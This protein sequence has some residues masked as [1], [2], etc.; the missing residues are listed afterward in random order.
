MFGKIN[1]QKQKWEQEEPELHRTG[2][3]GTSKLENVCNAIWAV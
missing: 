3:F 2:I 1:D